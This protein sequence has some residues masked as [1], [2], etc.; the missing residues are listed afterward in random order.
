MGGGYCDGWTTDGHSADKI[1]WHSQRNFYDD[2]MGES[3]GMKRKA[4][5]GPLENV[6]KAVDTLLS[7]TS[8]RE[9]ALRSKNKGGRPRVEGRGR[10]VLYLGEGQIYNLKRDALEKRQ[11]VSTLARAVLKKAGY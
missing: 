11:D 3:E 6:G 1:T 5:W 10:I 8:K 9:R 7:D 4:T 2:R